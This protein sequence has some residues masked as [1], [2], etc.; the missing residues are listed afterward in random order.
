MRGQPPHPPPTGRHCSCAPG[1][2]YSGVSGVAGVIAMFAGG[3]GF[4][5]GVNPWLVEET[6]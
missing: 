2:V 5:G 3:G 6:M 4:S 1:V